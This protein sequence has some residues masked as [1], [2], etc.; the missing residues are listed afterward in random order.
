M[1]HKNIKLNPKA[2]KSD[3]IIISIESKCFHVQKL[4]I[5]SPINLIFQVP[6]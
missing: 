4:G 1:S 5:K 6:I 3:N 2:I